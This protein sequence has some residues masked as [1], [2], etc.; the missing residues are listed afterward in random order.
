MLSDLART[1]SRSGEAAIK[2]RWTAMVHVDDDDFFFIIG[3]VDVEPPQRDVAPTNVGC[4]RQSI[5][6]PLTAHRAAALLL[7]T[8]NYVIPSIYRVCAKPYHLEHV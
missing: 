2:S 4:C 5:G 1:D 3:S 8:T 7:S 6:H